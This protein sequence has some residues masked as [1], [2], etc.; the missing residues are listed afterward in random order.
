[1]RAR[2]LGPRRILGIW[3]GSTGGPAPVVGSAVD[4]LVGWLAWAT[5][6]ATRAM[7]VV[8]ICECLA[9]RHTGVPTGL[10]YLVAASWAAATS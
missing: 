7:F 10:P 1:V 6:Y 3:L 2:G 9:G 4:C 8:I 5:T